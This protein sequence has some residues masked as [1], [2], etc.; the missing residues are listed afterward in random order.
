MSIRIRT[1]IILIFCLPFIPN[2]F[3][4][5]VKPGVTPSEIA[6]E[7]EHQIKSLETGLADKFTILSHNG[8]F[9]KDWHSLSENIKAIKRGLTTVYGQINLKI[10]GLTNEYRIEAFLDILPNGEFKKEFTIFSE[11]NRKNVHYFLYYLPIIIIL[12]KFPK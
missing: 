10:P 9:L 5:V 1:I 7:I 6:K 8:K 4:K 3:A 11:S 12:I 2:A